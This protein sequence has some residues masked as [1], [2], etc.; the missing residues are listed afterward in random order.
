MSRTW[1]GVF[2]A[3]ALVGGTVAGQ[4]QGSRGPHP[5][6]PLLLVSLARSSQQPAAPQA[7]RDESMKG[8]VLK[9][10]SPVSDEVLRVTLPRPVESDL[11]NGIH[12]MVMEN[13]RAPTVSF[14]LLI[15]G[16]GGYYDPADMPGLAELTATLMR[17][18]TKTLSSPEIAEKLE[19]L[20]A[21][22]NV[23]TSMGSQVATL[24]ASS[25]TE[26]FDQVV[27]IAADILLNPT[28]PEEELARTKT[29][30]RGGL[31]QQRGNP[32]FL[33]GELMS[34]VLYGSH[35]AGRVSI[36]LPVLQRVTHADLAAFHQKTYVPDFA[37]LGVSGDIT[38]REA[39]RTFEA[40][41]AG[42]KKAAVPRPTV[43]DPIDV[44]GA[45]VY[46]VDRADSVQT[47]LRVGAPAIS[48]LSPDYDVVSVMNKILG[49][50][51]TGRLFL[52]LRE[53]KGYTYGASSGFSA[54]RYRG[55]WQAST[56]VRS[57]VTGLALGEL[58]AE[59]RRLRDERVP[60][61]EF[62]NAKRS[63]VAAF[64]LSLESPGGI[65]NNHITRWLYGLPL[66]YLDTY[67]DR[68][69]AVTVEQVQAAARKYLDP[70]RL[71]I[72]A[73]GDGGKIADA[74]KTFGPVETYD[75][76]GKR[77]GG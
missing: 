2:V 11:P 4:P 26:N 49:G 55:G 50:G 12:L 22:V 52:N 67:P 63:M 1:M 42:W 77:I 62:R 20:A 47:S 68:I 34:R 38:A 37:V 32:G 27:A 70:S 58:M 6:S 65:L 9:G 24:T 8:A 10:K 13:H 39:R 54:L 69:M 66:D 19:T 71:Q 36:T 31:V 33:A 18:G 56:D 3:V 16:A 21:T 59:I 57:E 35:P 64:A 61:Q 43:S 75:T 15:Q 7:Q 41:L 17:E 5:R 51:P 28:F 48:R 72:V 40:A 74:L 25:L 76:E 23:D 46:F 45:K 53:D 73:V 30:M 29:R 14:Q 60:D 44:T